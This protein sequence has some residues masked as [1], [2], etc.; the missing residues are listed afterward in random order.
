MEQHYRV[1]PSRIDVVEWVIPNIGIE[2][3]PI[4][5]PDG[6]DL[7][8]ARLGGRASEADGDR[9][10]CGRDRPLRSGHVIDPPQDEWTMKNEDSQSAVAPFRW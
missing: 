2:V 9:D 4:L 1:C 6:I 3:D 8:E 7:Q 10:G 5:V